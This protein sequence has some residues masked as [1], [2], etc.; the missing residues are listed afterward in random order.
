M[1]TDISQFDSTKETRPPVPETF[2]VSCSISLKKVG[3]RIVTV[4]DSHFD[5][6]TLLLNAAGRPQSECFAASVSHKAQEPS[7][8]FPSNLGGVVIDPRLEA[9][10]IEPFV[11]N[12]I[13]SGP[14]AIFCRTPSRM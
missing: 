3:S 4:N 13:S 12:T 2:P 6:S 1:T 10:V 7:A 14:T 11:T 9:A 8:S 5:A